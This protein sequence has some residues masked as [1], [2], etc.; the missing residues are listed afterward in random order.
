MRM[1]WIGRCLRVQIA[2]LLSIC[3]GIDGLAERHCRRTLSSELSQIQ[4]QT[5]PA[6][7]FSLRSR[8]IMAY[9]R[10]L[11]IDVPEF[12]RSTWLELWLF[13]CQSLVEA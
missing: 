12:V 5:G 8:A 2:N 3:R 1:A 11:M 13:R 10:D 9:A 6:V 4:M 7:I